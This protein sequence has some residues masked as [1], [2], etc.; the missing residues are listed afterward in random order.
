MKICYEKY[1]SVDTPHGIGT[2]ISID[3]MS[4]PVVMYTV[5]YDNDKT[6]VCAEQQIKL[7]ISPEV[8]DRNGKMLASESTTAADGS[9]HS[10]FTYEYNRQIWFYVYFVDTHGVK[11]I[12]QLKMI[13]DLG[14]IE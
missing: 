8:L 10:L 4:S 12:K 11:H 9:I 1:C 2:I 14:E 13:Q 5:A 3:Y 6:C 7:T